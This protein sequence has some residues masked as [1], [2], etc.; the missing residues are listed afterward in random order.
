MRRLQ[1]D[2]PEG[3]FTTEVA[4]KTAVTGSVERFDEARN[5]KAPADLK[6]ARVLLVSLLALVVAVFIN[7]LGGEF[8]YDDLPQ[9][10]DNK[11][12]GRWDAQA[13]TWILSRDVRSSTRSEVTE[14]ISSNYY[15]PVA[16]FFMAVWHA[17]A[18]STPARWH[19]ASVLL[20]TLAVILVFAVV[21]R[22]LTALCIEGVRNRLTAAF[23]AAVFAVHPVQSESVAWI[24]A[25]MNPLSAVMILAAMLLYLK[26]RTEETA[27]K[28]VLMGAAAGLML[29]ALLTKESAIALLPIVVSY[30][31]FVFNRE[32]GWREK[33]R[34]CWVRTLPFA[35]VAAGYLG[36]RFAVMGSLFGERHLNANYPEDSSL[37]L[38]DHLYTSPLLVLHYLKSILWPIDLS[39]TYDLAFVRGTVKPFLGPAL[40]LLVGAALLLYLSRRV[41]EAR[42]AALWIVIPLAPYLNT[43]SFQ[44]GDLVHDRYLYVSMAGVGLLASGLLRKTAEK[45]IPACVALAALLI[46]GLAAATVLQNAV[47][48]NSRT[49]WLTALERAPN[50]RIARLWLG[51]HA[52]EAR[53]LDAA[54]QHYEAALRIN[55]DIVDALTNL[56]FVYAQQ[57]R[58]EEAIEKFERITS[59][60]PEDGLS[61][62]N[63]SVAYA[64]RK[65]FRDELIVLKKAIELEPQHPQV[66]AW[67]KRLSDLESVLAPEGGR[68]ETTDAKS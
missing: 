1:P 44:S 66:D 3:D 56:A 14:G 5:T 39:V 30:E 8:V 21:K 29:L 42:L 50:S 18:R 26:A 17:I 28:T 34:K 55:P 13:I 37:T 52:E 12:L 24:S 32:L 19:L 16:T 7:S 53:D 48:R 36:L 49:L 62:F 11:L 43:S 9:I 65:R 67:R 31:L 4:E 61:H 41:V 38:L 47:W 23:S 57:G 15:R 60:L 45:S 63:L 22:S 35:T 20:H 6:S 25:L 51:A 64:A 33:L 59:L 68:S 46:T 40:L 27:R 2:S 10:R 54:A 58:W